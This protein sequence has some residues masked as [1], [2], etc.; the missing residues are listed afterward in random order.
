MIG[1]GSL[2]LSEHL[3]P[4]HYVFKWQIHSKRL[5][6]LHAE[7]IP[8]YTVMEI[9]AF[10]WTGWWLNMNN[11]PWLEWALFCPMDNDRFALYLEAAACRSLFQIRA[12]RVVA[13]VFLVVFVFFIF[14]LE[15]RNRLSDFCKKGF[16]AI[17]HAPCLIAIR[18][19]FI[20][21]I[22][23]YW[24]AD[25]STRESVFLTHLHLSPRVF[26]IFCLFCQVCCVVDFYYCNWNTH[27][28]PVTLE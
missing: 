22:S 10:H 2:K 17:L 12:F 9:S 25:Y 6:E 13:A 26:F 20:L 21:I 1:A 8:K 18:V 7:K 16:L 23:S 27:A 19:P 3:T 4:A 5:L 15:N 11:A 14:A 24:A 28:Y